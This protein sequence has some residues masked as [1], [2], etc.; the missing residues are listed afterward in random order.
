VESVKIETTQP[1]Q[2]PSTSP[3]LPAPH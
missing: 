3:A 1:A 2:P